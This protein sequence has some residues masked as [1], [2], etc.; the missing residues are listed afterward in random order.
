MIVVVISGGVVQDV[1]SPTKDRVL[2]VD[3]DNKEIGEEFIT[4]MSVS[5][6][7]KMY[8]ELNRDIMKNT[9]WDA[10]DLSTPDP[11]S[12]NPPRRG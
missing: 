11:P 1:Y 5:H 4:L 12:F 2:I 9:R 3:Y 7:A 6:P 10:N 8:S